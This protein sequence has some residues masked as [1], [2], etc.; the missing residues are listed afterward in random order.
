MLNEKESELLI[1]LFEFADKNKVTFHPVQDIIKKVKT[2]AANDN[3]C[4]CKPD[5]RLC[6]CTEAVKE[7]ETNG[8]CFCM[9]F[10]TY[11]YGDEYIN[12][13]GYLKDGKVTS[14]KERKQIVIN[15]TKKT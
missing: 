13:W 3:K 15:K 2:M 8:K 9:L 11:K 14:D 10:C 4:I 5:E 12:K 6:P 7:L 1:N